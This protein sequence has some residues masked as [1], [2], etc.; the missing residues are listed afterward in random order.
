MALALSAMG[1]RAAAQT[2][3][4][5]AYSFDTQRVFSP[6]TTA[7]LTVCDASGNPTSFALAGSFVA[8]GSGW[9]TG[10]FSG[11]MPPCSC[12][13]SLVGSD[14]NTYR[15]AVATFPLS[16]G[17]LVPPPR[18]SHVELLVTGVLPTA[19]T[20][21]SGSYDI[22]GTL[23]VNGNLFTLGGLNTNSLAAGLTLGFSDGYTTTGALSNPTAVTWTGF[24]NNTQWFWQKPSHAASGAMVQ[25]MW[26]DDY[27]TLSLSSDT[28][29]NAIVLD[30]VSGNISI[31]GAPVVVS[32][33]SAA[34]SVGIGSV[35]NASGIDSTAIGYYASAS[36]FGSFA[37]GYA[38]T[39]SGLDSIAIGDYATT[40]SAATQS[41]VIGGNN[42]ASNINS[43]VVGNGGT[44]SGQ[45]CSVVGAYSTASNLGAAAIGYRNLAAGQ[46]SYALGRGLIANGF[47]QT[48]VGSYNVPVGNTAATGF[49]G[50]SD[51]VFVV[52]NGD[53]GTGNQSNALTISKGGSLAAGTGVTSVQP[54]QAV[55]GMNNDPRPN[56]NG[57]DHTQGVFIVGNGTGNPNDPQATKQRNALRVT[58]SGAVLIQPQGD[59]SMGLFAS[60]AKP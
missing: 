55:L 27:G 10:T 14:G 37:A 23:D 25:P 6:E 40:T 17:N 59:I 18:A 9:F 50:P 3:Y 45:Y 56:D 51:I 33:G 58:A 34:G 43:V 13:F 57:V 38:V 47:G 21:L 28:S 49:S 41:V 5:V 8:N 35:V 24:R 2:A 42:T 1:L 60:G 19:S 44:A 46:Y 29:K 26:L 22:G 48:V 52:G 12:T 31:W 11:C 30:P 7:T 53:S 20:Q 54:S 32:K 16:G 36:G 39:A 4:P 15:S